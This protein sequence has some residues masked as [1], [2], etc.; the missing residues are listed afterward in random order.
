[1]NSLNLS[2][3]H[4]LLQLF[5]FIKIIRFLRSI[6]HSDYSSYFLVILFHFFIF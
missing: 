2:L 1:M 4:H 3:N 5:S 6:L